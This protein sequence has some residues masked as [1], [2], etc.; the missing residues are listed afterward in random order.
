[1]AFVV[2]SYFLTQIINGFVTDDFI[3][4]LANFFGSEGIESTLDTYYI[5]GIS[6]S[7]VIALIILCAVYKYRRRKK[8]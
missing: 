7:A 2:L 1:V 3:L 8:D 6:V 4:Q 5:F